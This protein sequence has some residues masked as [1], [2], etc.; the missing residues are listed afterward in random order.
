[1]VRLSPEEFTV[2]V[3]YISSL[4][5]VKL[6]T[7]K[8]YLIET[9]LADLLAHH[10]CAS[11]SELYYKAKS[12]RESQL[13]QEIIDRI[14][15]NETSFFRDIAPFDM[16]RNK[17]L[18]DLIDRR[19]AVPGRPFPVKIWSAACSTG[20]ELYTIAIILRE[21]LGPQALGSIRLMGTDISNQAIKSASR[22]VYNS[23]EISRGLPPSHQQR[24]FQETPEG[25]KLR[26]EIRAM[27]SFRQFNLLDNLSQLGQ[28]DIV[29]CRN[30]AIYFD[31]RV[32]Q[33]LFNRIAHLLPPDGYL[34]IGSTES[35]SGLCPVFVP[36]R[37]L[38]SVYYQKQT[39][40]I[41]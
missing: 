6:D 24:Y 22:A 38:R 11:F 4:C 17:I 19:R 37:H 32:K 20:Q 40:P 3:R 25:W 27:A 41:G 30:V 18:P 8:A 12:S 34:V 10:R 15:T 13:P 1:M 28:F 31:E 26:D 21:L 35:I 36:H 7:G 14:T 2:W 33:D 9:R 16:L 5:G 23:V 29:F 39:A